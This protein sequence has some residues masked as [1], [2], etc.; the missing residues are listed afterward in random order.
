MTNQAGGRV[1]IVTGSS[2][3][4]GRAIAIALAQGGADVL[5]N[6]RDDAAA[7]Q[8][9]VDA[10]VEAG[11]RAHVVQANVGKSAEVDRLVAA[12]VSELGPPT[13]LVN[14]AGIGKRVL[15]VADLDIDTWNDTI[16]T[17][18]TAPFL[19]TQAVVPYMRTAG[20]GRIINISSTAAQTGGSVGPHYA[21][22][23]AG[24]IGLTHGY[25]S[26]LVKEGITVNA[27]AMAQIET[28]MLRSATAADPSRIPIGRFG[29]VDEVAA[30]A[31]MLVDNAYMT[32]QTISLNG[33]MYYTS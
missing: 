17:N 27:I 18:L 6:Y 4:M 25:A 9:A 21:A 32:G 7:A 23:K 26:K 22:S 31:T 15:D 2:R 13:I 19:M 11:R 5:I 20:W 33:G 8:S 30:V 29:T 24:I 1:A 16:A 3:G 14:N 10:I 28:D 12:C